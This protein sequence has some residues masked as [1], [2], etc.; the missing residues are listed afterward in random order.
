MSTNYFNNSD[1]SYTNSYANNQSIISYQESDAKCS[2]NPS[3]NSN[4][5]KK[6]VKF[7]KTLTTVKK[8]SAKKWRMTSKVTST[9][10]SAANNSVTSAK[11][12]KTAAPAEGTY[13]Y[14]YYYDNNESQPPPPAI[15]D[16]QQ[17]QTYNN[18]IAGN[19]YYYY[20]ID[21]TSDANYNEYPAGNNESHNS[22]RMIN[23]NSSW[24]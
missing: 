11:M 18:N 3:T 4:S 8:P 19:Y 20:T 13:Y 5:N 1:S 9:T 7:S 6:H 24:R 23:S 17:Q 22:Q 2:H 10:Q 12:G 16:E 14:Y 15:N 21:G